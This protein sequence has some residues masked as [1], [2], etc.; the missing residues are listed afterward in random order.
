ML[1]TSQLTPVLIPLIISYELSCP[2]SGSKER[3]FHPGD[4][5]AL[6]VNTRPRLVPLPTFLARRDINPGIK[7]DAAYIVLNTYP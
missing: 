7:N 6:A 4:T 2:F 5:F 1:K 3:K